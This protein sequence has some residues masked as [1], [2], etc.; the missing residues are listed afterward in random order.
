M[1]EDKQPMNELY[2][3]YR[4]FSELQ[5][6]HAALEATVTYRLSNIEGGIADVKSI[7]LRTPPPQQVQHE[8]AVNQTLLAMHDVAKSIRDGR[9]DG[10][11]SVVVRALAIVGAVAIGA[12]GMW[13][14]IH[15]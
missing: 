10:S 5:R 12:T 4:E 7:L 11:T 6:Q 3:S 9:S 13:F 8:S 1:T 15:H 2:T 14:F